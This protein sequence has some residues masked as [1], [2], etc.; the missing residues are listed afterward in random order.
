MR[1]NLLRTAAAATLVFLLAGCAVSARGAVRHEP[2]SSGARHEPSGSGARSEPA[3]SAGSKIAS[4][5]GSRI[6]VYRNKDGEAQRTI[7]SPNGYGATRVFLVERDEGEWLQVLLPIRPNGS[8]GWIRA[9]DVT[10]AET[11]YRVEIDRGAF[12]FTVYDGER[13]VRTGKVATGEAGTPTPP[14]RYFFTE[15]VKPADDGGA[16]GA[17][18]F[19]LSGFSPVLKSFAGGPGQLALH[20]TNK[21]SAIGTRASHGCVRLSN[22]DITWMAK[23]LAIGTPVV[24]KG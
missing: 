1:T 16:Y 7:T 17:Y 20:G 18:A 11:S 14:G 21:P 9:A 5:K 19:G 10:L 24:V 23:N 22:D 15:L 8:K 2:S 12:R 4:V 6:T 3:S 13:A